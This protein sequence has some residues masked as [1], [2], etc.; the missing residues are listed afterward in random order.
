MLHFWGMLR[1][2]TAFVATHFWVFMLAGLGLGLLYPRYASAL[3]PLLEPALA[4]LLLLVFLKTDLLGILRSIRDFRLMGYAS[5]LYLIVVPL[6]VYLLL[7]PLDEAL[8]VGM[9]LL[10]AMPPGTA[11]PA[12]SDLLRGNVQLSMSLAIVGSLLAPFTVPLLFYTVV[13]AQLELDLGQ[14]FIKMMLLVFVPMLASQLLKHGAPRLVKAS[15]PYFSAINV[16]IFFTFVYATL[17]SQRHLLLAH[18]WQVVEQLGW[19]YGV[20]VLLHVL[21]FLMAWGRPWPDKL[22]LVIGHAYMNNGLAIVL[23]ASFFEPSVLVLMVLSEFPWNTF[24]VGLRW[25]TRRWGRA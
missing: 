25:A 12:L 7:R 17:G 16:L 4:F 5:L 18:P 1:K 22:S 15:M 6:G 8:A 19:M 14:V 21:G 24:P 9:L 11:T 23:A 2:L 13:G 10:T 20:F 3:M